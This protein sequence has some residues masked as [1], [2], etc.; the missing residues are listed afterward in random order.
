MG[1][2]LR[3]LFRAK[4]ATNEVALS[5]FFEARIEAK[6]DNLERLT[7]GARAVYMGNNRVLTKVV[8]NG[9]NFAYLVE[10][11]DLLITPWFIITGTYEIP[12]TNYFLRNIKPNSHC[13][14]VGSNFGFFTCLFSRIA[15][16]GRVFAI[17][18]DEHVYKLCRDN[19]MINGL[20]NV[21]TA[22]HAAAN[23]DGAS[24]MLHR[25]MGRSGNTSI[26][27][28]GREFTDWHGEAP[29][30]PFTVNGLKIDDLLDR[31]QGRV[32]FIKIDV[33]GA[34]PLA[35][36]GAWHTIKSNPQLKIVMEWSPG[37]VVAAG[38]NIS[39]FLDEISSQGLRF[40]DLDTN[41]P[42]SKH[43][44]MKSDYMPGLLMSR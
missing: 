20:Q 27:D 30:E 11:N 25:R 12:L 8:V 5:P 15:P 38:G 16:Q 24:M 40:F 29:S 36:R 6:I 21:G 34:E 43:D 37:Q 22:I 13:L 33:E 31:M 1:A 44:V 41:K 10:A 28:A 42:L 19:I 35:L 3:N 32:D 14:D 17:E 18:A 4:E 39:D 26:I 9:F 7:H 2:T 23:E